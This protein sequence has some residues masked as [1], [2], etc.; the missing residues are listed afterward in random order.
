MEL[1]QA[2]AKAWELVAQKAQGRFRWQDWNQEKVK[3]GRMTAADRV[4]KYR[5]HRVSQG[6]DEDTWKRPYWIADKKLSLDRLLTET[7][8]LEVVPILLG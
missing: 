2:E 3:L 8:I 4:E 1:E 7:N 6:M 5:L